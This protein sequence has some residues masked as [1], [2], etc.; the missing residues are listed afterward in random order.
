MKN[1]IK[2]LSK[3]DKFNNLEYISLSHVA[4]S[5]KYG[6]F[7]CGCGKEKAISIYHV[8]IGHTKSCGCFKIVSPKLGLSRKTH[9]KS[10][11]RLYKA[12]NS[13][14]G[15]C[16]S[17]NAHGY[18]NYGGR[19]IFVCNEWKSDYMPFELWALS[20]GYESHLTLD[21]I[22]VNGNYEPSNCRWITSKE[23]HSNKRN[24]HF[25]EYNGEKMTVTQWGMKLQNDPSFVAHRLTKGWDEIRA[26]S[27][28][29]SHRHDTSKKR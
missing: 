17:K 20:N 8:I 14:M 21:R 5:V 4:K 28:P 18:H 29:K 2:E 15:R 6:L 9:G 10:T 22:D 12:W 3:G 19:G 13:M 23:Q 7:K 1:K 16:Y 26:V 11:T 27:T 24:N 25:I